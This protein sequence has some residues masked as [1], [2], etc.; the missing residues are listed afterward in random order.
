MVSELSLS[1][2]VLA[3]VTSHLDYLQSLQLFSLPPISP[4]STQLP[5]PPGKLSPQWAPLSPTCTPDKAALCT[6]SAC[7]E[8]SDPSPPAWDLRLSSDLIH[9]LSPAAPS[10]QQVRSRLSPN[11]VH[12][13]TN[14]S[15]LHLRCPT[16]S[17]YE[18]IPLGKDELV[19]NFLGQSLSRVILSFS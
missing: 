8:A 19:L 12:F 7:W 14:S 5:Q 15:V 3:P 2:S 1:L 18:F 9:R 4:S 16:L 11:T 13:N 6:P 17:P 10:C